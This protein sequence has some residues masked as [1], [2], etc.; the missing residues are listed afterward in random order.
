MGEPEL[1]RMQ[2]ARLTNKAAGCFV[3]V[4]GV[5][6]LVGWLAG[7]GGLARYALTG[8]VVGAA[9]WVLSLIPAVVATVR[10]TR[11]DRE[12]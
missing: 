5:V 2:K 7:A 6:G 3:L 1:D 4:F 10:E 8:A 9:V 12:G 11:K